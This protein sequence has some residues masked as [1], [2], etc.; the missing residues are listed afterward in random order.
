MCVDI[1]AD[2]VCMRYAASVRSMIARGDA[3]H[4]YGSVIGWVLVNKLWRGS[5]VGGQWEGVHM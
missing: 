5:M 3:A 2:F 1:E 4:A